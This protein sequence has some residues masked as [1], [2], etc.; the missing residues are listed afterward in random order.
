VP[1]AP[2]T[3]AT[4]SNGLL[5][6]VLAFCSFSQKARA[7]CPARLKAQFIASFVEGLML[8]ASPAWAA[9]NNGLLLSSC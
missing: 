6:V 5:L 9:H 3:L 7:A 4:H 1:F 8:F 2:P